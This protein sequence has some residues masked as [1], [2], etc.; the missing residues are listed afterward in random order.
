MEEEKRKMELELEERIRGAKIQSSKLLEGGKLEAKS[1]TEMIY[2]ENENALTLEH[3]RLINEIRLTNSD[4]YKITK[5]SEF[6]A[7]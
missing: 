7:A 3:Y 2:Q 5:E 6:K 1:V 4:K